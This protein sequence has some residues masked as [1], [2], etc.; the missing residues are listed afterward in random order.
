MIPLL[1]NNI[2]FHVYSSF[3]STTLGYFFIVFLSQN[4]AE[5]T[6]IAIFF[7]D[8]L[9]TQA[10]N[11]HMHI[12]WLIHSMPYILPPTKVYVLLAIRNEV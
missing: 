12:A 7:S 5:L 8:C 2:M 3:L 1:T 11:I 10:K 4:T 9:Y 6:G